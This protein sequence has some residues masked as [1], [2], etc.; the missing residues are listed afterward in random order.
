MDTAEELLTVAELASWL[1]K[2][3]S[4]IYNRLTD[5]GIPHVRLGN[6]IRFKRSEVEA[7]LDQQRAA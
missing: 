2:P 3:R 7:W 6:H 1:R 5:L 4:W